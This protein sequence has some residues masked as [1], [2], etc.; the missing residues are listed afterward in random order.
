MLGLRQAVCLL[1]PIFRTGY[2]PV[3]TITHTLYLCFKAKS[4]EPYNFQ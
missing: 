4:E 1:G 3:T 2:F